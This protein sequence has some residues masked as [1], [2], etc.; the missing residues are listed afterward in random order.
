MHA[1]SRL[2]KVLKYLKD[3][4]LRKGMVINM[5]YCKL[6]M[7]CMLIVLYIAF[8]YIRE[9]VAYRIKRKEWVFELLLATGVLCIAFDGLL[10]I[11]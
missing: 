3:C 2:R 11:P 5:Q 4:R 7:G 6:Q 1:N 8:I 9:K 10:L